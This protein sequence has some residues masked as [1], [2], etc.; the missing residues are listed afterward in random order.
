MDEA[1]LLLLLLLDEET[2]LGGA[3]NCSRAHSRER[4]GVDL[5]LA[6]TPRPSPTHSP[7]PQLVRKAGLPQAL[8][9]DQQARWRSTAPPGRL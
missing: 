1:G 8:V 4:L 9:P 2:Q 3:S 6:W 7:C 5:S